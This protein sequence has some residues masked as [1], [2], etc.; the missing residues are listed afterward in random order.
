MMRYQMSV[1]DGQMS[2][3]QPSIII[4]VKIKKKK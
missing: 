1:I 4:K 2:V 3:G